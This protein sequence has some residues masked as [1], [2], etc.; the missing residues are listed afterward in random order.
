MLK[1]IS[2]YGRMIYLLNA[3]YLIMTS[4]TRKLDERKRDKEKA[5]SH[6]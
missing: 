2:L 5:L 4:N 3:F 6:I 1:I